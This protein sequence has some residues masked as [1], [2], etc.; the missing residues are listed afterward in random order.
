[1]V[2]KWLE[3]GCAVVVCVWL[4]SRTDAQSLPFIPTPPYVLSSHR[5]EIACPLVRTLLWVTE[6]CNLPHTIKQ[7]PRCTAAVPL[8]RLERRAGQTHMPLHCPDESTRHATTPKSAKTTRIAVSPE[9]G[10]FGRAATASNP[11][12]SPFGRAP[13][14]SSARQLARPSTRMS[15]LRV[16]SAMSPVVSENAMCVMS[17]RASR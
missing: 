3:C 6:T 9:R 4:C 8:E 11:P 2:K 13:K 1:M 12:T 17:S 7:T 5:V 15:P 16:P 10:A 14:G